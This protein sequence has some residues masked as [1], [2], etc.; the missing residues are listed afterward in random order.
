MIG[1]LV[2]ED[3]LACLLSIRIFQNQFR[4][5]GPDFRADCIFVT[6]EFIL[7]GEKVTESENSFT[8]LI[9]SWS[10]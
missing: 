4:A 7:D 9:S 1:R 3:L 10:A 5:P 2:G 6:S 8:N